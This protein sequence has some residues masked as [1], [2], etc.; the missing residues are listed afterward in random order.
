M[1][2]TLKRVSKSKMGL[3]SP[4]LCSKSKSPILKRVSKSKMGLK[5]PK[6]YSKSKSPILKRVSKSKMGLKSPKLCLKSRNPILLKSK[7]PTITDLHCTSSKRS[8]QL[9]NSTN[10]LMSK[11]LRKNAFKLKKPIVL[12][13]RLS[14]IIKVTSSSSL[15]RISIHINDQFSNSNINIS[16]KIFDAIFNHSQTI[17]HD[18]LKQINIPY[19]SQTH[20]LKTSPH[21]KMIRTFDNVSTA[22]VEPFT[23]STPKEKGIFNRTNNKRNTKQISYNDDTTYE[24]NEQCSTLNVQKSI[25]STTEEK[26]GKVKKD[27][28]YELIEPKTPNLRKKLY[29]KQRTEYENFDQK[30]RKTDAKVCFANCSLDY[31]YNSSLADHNK[32]KKLNNVKNNSS[33]NSSKKNITKSLTRDFSKKSNSI[34]EIVVTTPSRNQ[35]PDSKPATTKKVPNFAKIHKKIFAKAE[36]IIDAR[37]RVIDRYTELT[38]RNEKTNSRGENQLSNILNKNSYNQ[39]KLKIRKLEATDCI[40]RNNTLRVTRNKEQSRAVLKGV[41]TNRRFEL[42]MNFRNMNQ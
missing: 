5:S 8:S 26:Q 7:I 19:K 33:K 16:Q 40:M 14:D 20:F 42:Q 28:T 17:S 23:S 24:L 6:L 30:I 10:I 12:L 27:D 15:P 32:Q 4:K 21:N 39:F 38:T 11:M 18:K 31:K 9:E 22:F 34:P 25:A 1:R 13:K 2:Y 37:K 35:I 36:S 3:K 41:R 29:K